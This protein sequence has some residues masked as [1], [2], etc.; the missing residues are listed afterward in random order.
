MDQTVPHLNCPAHIRPEQIF[1]FDVYD[2][3]VVEDDIQLSLKRIFDTAP[4]IFYT[5]RNDGHWVVAKYDLVTKILNDNEHFSSRRQDIPKL[6]DTYCLIPMNIDPPDNLPYRS[7]L[8]KHF[9]GGPVSKMDNV[10]RDWARQLIRSVAGLGRCDFEDLGARF[11]VYIFMELMGLPLERFEYFRSLV[12]GYFGYIEANERLSI[13]NA[14]C[15]E[16]DQLIA[17][18]KQER[19]DDLVSK[20]IDARIGDRPLTPV[21]LQGICFT[22]FIG[23]L[24]SVASSLNFVLYHLAKDARLQAQ[25]AAHKE[26]I[27]SF[28][29]EAF[30]RYAIANTT[31]I[32]IKDI[33]FEGVELREGDMV[34]CSLPVSGLDNQKFPN[35]GEI[36][37]DRVGKSHLGFST[38]AHT[39]VGHF[40]AR[41]EVRV[42]VEEWL[43]E[44]PSFS[45]AE[46]FTPKFRPGLVVQLR[47]LAL[48][49]T[50][51]E[52]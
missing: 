18:R 49:W 1:D 42:F 48:R 23:G 43:R 41:A 40:L 35:A 32:V 52:K 25:L 13:Q 10:M 11:P 33:K 4:D 37:L 5:P 45:V 15:D 14:I 16:L 27:S 28:V 26:K 20:L 24:D 6:E 12:A 17:A 39:C 36:D 9:A 19:A 47:Q 46:G 31:R 8:M 44:I 30:R 7:I 22:L 2:H 3:A 50:P 34:L 51:L 38:G 29:E 21:E